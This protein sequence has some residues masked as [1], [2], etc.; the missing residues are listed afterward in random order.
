MRGLYLTGLSALHPE[1]GTSPE[2]SHP[3]TIPGRCAPIMP[4][5]RDATREGAALSAR[6]AARLA[7]AVFGLAVLLSLAALAVGSRRCMRA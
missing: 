5:V 2:G 3:V 4:M 1:V 7:W 6:V